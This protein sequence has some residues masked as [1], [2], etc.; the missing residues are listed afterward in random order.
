MT[1]EMGLPTTLVSPAMVILSGLH[2]LVSVM[3]HEVMTPRLAAVHTT[4]ATVPA[5]TPLHLKCAPI[6]NA[7]FF[8]VPC[9][10]GITC[11]EFS[12][13]E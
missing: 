2:L 7:T 4:F 9:V 6:V 1:V 5:T 3:E 12:R 13:V 10:D 11:R 8:F